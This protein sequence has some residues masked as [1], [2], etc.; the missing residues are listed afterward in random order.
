M[1][2]KN[3][4]T[5]VTMTESD[6]KHFFGEETFKSTILGAYTGLE[7]AKADINTVLSKRIQAIA[8]HY[9]AEIKAGE[10]A[11]SD[12]IDRLATTDKPALR[13]YY[14]N[15]IVETKNEIARDELRK[16]PETEVT[17]APDGTL[18]GLTLRDFNLGWRCSFVLHPVNITG[19]LESPIQD[20]VGIIAAERRRQI[21]EEG[22]RLIDD[23]WYQNDELALAGATYAL[24]KR[25]R[26]NHNTDGKGLRPRYWPFS[27]YAWK[28]T[29]NDRIRELAKAGA[30]IAAEI[31]RELRAGKK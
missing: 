19:D 5:V 8:R 11:I 1:N 20:G 15:L 25:L 4:V 12:H 24:P 29:P 30:L 27:P 31:D 7:P 26:H 22:Y 3:T 23:L 10:Q 6:E 21:M 18:I 9:D 13:I 2:K 16:I 14:N 28:P 17:N